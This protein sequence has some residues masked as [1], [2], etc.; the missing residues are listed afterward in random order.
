[1]SHQVMDG[2]AAAKGN[3]L[4]AP[5]NNQGVPDSTPVNA[6]HENYATV[7]PTTALIVIG[8]CNDNTALTFDNSVYNLS[9][10]IIGL[11]KRYH[12]SKKNDIL[13]ENLTKVMKMSMSNQNETTFAM[14]KLVKIVKG[15]KEDFKVAMDLLSM[16]S[17]LFDL[18][19]KQPT[20]LQ[21]KVF[22][23]TQIF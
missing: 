13:R 18:A 1:M 19:S 4:I 9:E 14:S 7:K 16:I 15:N 5:G 12:H 22:Q 6:N 10:S 8:D 11:L 23:L 3:A 20:F 17:D 21:H 2:H